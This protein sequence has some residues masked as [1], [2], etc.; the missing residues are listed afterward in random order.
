MNKPKFEISEESNNPTAQVAYGV[1]RA[2]LEANWEKLDSLL[3]PGFTYTGDGYHFS[4]DE[5]I[6]FMQDM[7][8]AFSNF[9]MILERTITEG[10]MTSIRFTSHVINTGSFMGSP[11][12][13]KSL[14]VAGI[15]Q[16]KVQNGKVVQEWQTTDLLGTMNQI[17][18]GA[19]L[20]YAIFVT[21]FKVKSKPIQRKGN[22]FLH[23]NGSVDHFDILDGPSKNAYLKRYLKT[24]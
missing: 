16:R 3:A 20:G 12:N 22:D 1:S 5:Y 6:G 17:G 15:F 4:K 2:I 13:N 24:H 10:E 23:L 8:A 19:M 21:G 7:R 9:H 18:V 14:T 11:A